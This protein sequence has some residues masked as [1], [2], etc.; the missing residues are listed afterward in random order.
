M[1]SIEARKTKS[2][3]SYHITVD[4]GR[5][6]DGN[7]IRYRKTYIPEPGMTKKQ[8]DRAANRVA[9]DFERSIEQGYVPDDNRTF[10]EYAQYVLDLKLENKLRIRTY[11]RYQELLR[12]INPHIGHL[13]LTE[14]RAYHLNILYSALRQPKLRDKDGSATANID[15]AAWLRENHISR[16]EVSRRSGVSPVTVGTAAQGKT[17][18]ASKARL[19]AQAM[20]MDAEDVFSITKDERKLADKTVL[21][22]H[23]LVHTILAQADKEMLVPYN[24]ADKATAP[25]VEKT[26]PNYFQPEV[27]HQLLEALQAVSL[28]W[29]ALVHFLIVTGCRRGE[30]VGLRWTKI[31]WKNNTVRIDRALVESKKNGL[32]EDDTKTSDRRTLKLPQQTMDLLRELREEQRHWQLQYADSWGNS[33]YVFC[34]EDGTPTRPSTV[35]SWLRDFSARYDFPHINPHAFR[36][37]AASILL[38]T[39]D[40]VTVA[41][42][43]GH[44]DPATT[45]KYYAHIIDENKA[46]AAECIADVLLSKKG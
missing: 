38:G 3:V 46:K 10:A 45:S 29:R 34:R 33:G 14:I 30:A 11:E 15:I 44:K 41:A 35:T 6:A 39:Q 18:S 42:Y 12:R 26:V 21:E 19:I 8:A 5:D 1:A 20:G 4:G 17:I 27:V 43:L 32:Y 31:D 2:G 25:K 13:K 7:R 16:A 22:Y 40:I 23:R 36:H 37:T 24:A 9:V 28:R